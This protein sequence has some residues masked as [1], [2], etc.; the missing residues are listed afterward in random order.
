MENPSRAFASRGGTAVTCTKCGA[1]TTVPFVP[2]PGRPVYCRSCFASAG[3]GPS[4]PAPSGPA[5]STGYGAPRPSGGG[6]FRRDGPPP[7]SRNN[8]QNARRRMLAQG[9]KGHFV[10]DVREVLAGSEG[11][12]D[13]AQ[14]RMFVEMVFTRGARMGTEA[15]VDF[16]REKRADDTLTSDEAKRIERLLEKYSFYR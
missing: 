2:T 13:E 1:A 7:R 6:G 5:P 10:Y 4:G 9:R 15:A 3:P 16:V 8:V 14:R 12:I 11:R